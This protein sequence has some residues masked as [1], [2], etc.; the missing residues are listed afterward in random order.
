M[1]EAEYAGPERRR[2]RR[3]K[4]PLSL[5]FRA[6]G[7]GAFAEWDIV[8]IK[9]IGR[10]GLSFTYD[11]PMKEGM[12]LNMKLN[13]GLDRGAIECAGKVV[14]AK[15]LG[16]T[17]IQEVGVTFINLNESDAGS[18]DKAAAAFYAK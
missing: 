1:A 7:G 9:D 4:K 13:L 15:G 12:L 2:S 3:L 18:I 11:K 6:Q 17:K 16:A 10:V 14:R 5:R 8:L